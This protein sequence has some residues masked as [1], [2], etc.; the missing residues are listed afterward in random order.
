MTTKEADEFQEV[1]RL[2]S[3]EGGEG[4]GCESHILSD[5]KSTGSMANKGEV[6]PSVVAGHERLVSLI[7]D[8]TESF[9]GESADGRSS[10]RRGGA[11]CDLH[12][13]RQPLDH[14]GGEVAGRAQRHE[15]DTRRAHRHERLQ[16]RL[17]DRYAPPPRRA[18]TWQP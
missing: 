8:T 3:H 1:H 14:Q 4:R 16:V 15:V 18:L 10:G 17:H 2:C 11:V 9:M 12:R 7:E 6:P 13:D 5:G